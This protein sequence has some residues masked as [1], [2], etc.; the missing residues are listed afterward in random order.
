VL[1]GITGPYT[2]SRLRDQVGDHL[3][4]I[5]INA[6]LLA[7]VDPLRRDAFMARWMREIR[8]LDSR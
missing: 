2:V 1:P 5:P 3:Y 6:T 8:I 4:P 7:F